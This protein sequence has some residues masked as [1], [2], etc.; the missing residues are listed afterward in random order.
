MY[1]KVVACIKKRIIYWPGSS[2]QENNTLANF[3]HI[4]KPIL[5]P[6][7]IFK[8]NFLVHQWSRHFDHE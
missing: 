3:R 1:S 4:D 6:T 5:Y 8:N 7:Q 2:E